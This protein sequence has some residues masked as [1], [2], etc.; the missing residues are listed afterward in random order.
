MWVYN[1]RSEAD[2]PIR[3]APFVNITYL[4]YT[5]NLPKW[6][7]AYHHHENICE[8]TFVTGGSGLLCL[9]S[10]KMSLKKGDIVIMPPNVLHCYSCG[11][12]ET[13]QYYSMWVDLKSGKGSVA[14]FLREIR[15][16]PA[17][18][19]AHKY[20]E[21]IL[22]SFQIIE[23]LHH[24][25]HGLVDETYQTVCLSLL[26]MIK[27]IYSHKSMIIPVGSSSYASDVLWYINQ[28]HGENIT[29]E[30]LAEEFNISASHLRRIFKQVYDISPISYLI[31]R[32][33]AIATDLLLKTD[34]SI[35]EIAKAV[36]Y[37][38]VTHFSKLFAD[39]IG[40]TPSQFREQNLHQ[41]K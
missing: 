31:K 16:E 20:L 40:C 39:R 11:S 21:Y 27:K 9:E 37:E 5:D 2:N 13:M 24:V 23:E 25:N 4:S 28:H 15:S 26:M 10:D 8:L 6:S 29:L 1:Y 30:K 7:Y 22:S 18:V 38:N 33:I 34:L 41:L 19:S 3:E 36:G 12:R 32:R 35:T 17:I 14:D